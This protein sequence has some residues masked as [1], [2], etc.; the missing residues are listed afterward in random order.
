[1]SRAV[2]IR[3]IDPS[4]LGPHSPLL[5]LMRRKPRRDLEHQEQVK[6]FEWAADHEAKYPDL[7]WLFAVPNFAGR[8][9]KRTARHGARL[10][11]E[12]RKPGV[13]DIWLPVKHAHEPCP[14][15]VIELKAGK[16]VPTADQKRWIAHLHRQGWA[17][18]VAYSADVVIRVIEDYLN[19][20]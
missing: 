14:G 8:L 4:M 16:N 6:V 7:E 13:L 10:K 17:V 5:A 18:V 1:V 12:G 3:D 11:A 20:R 9:G 2:S 15:L 19:G